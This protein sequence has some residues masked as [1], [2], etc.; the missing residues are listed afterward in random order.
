MKARAL[1]AKAE[2]AAAS[3]R[4]LASSG[5]ADG[6]CNR[7]YYA[8][9]DAARAALAAAGHDGGRTH[10]GVINAFSHHLIQNGILAKDLGR[11]LKQA[12]VRR[13]IADYGGDTIE[14]ADAAEMVAQ[15]DL[16]IAAIR[17]TLPPSNQGPDIG[18]PDVP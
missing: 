4:L 12:E 16:F 7:A 3:A 8:M 14:S 9:F 1:L 17:E 2:Q 11:L 18:R 15:A 10:K 13:Y 5:D 6:A